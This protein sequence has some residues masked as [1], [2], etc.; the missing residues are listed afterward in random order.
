MAVTNTTLYFRT[1]AYIA[2]FLL[3]GVSLLNGTVQALLLAVWSGRFG[4]EGIPLRTNYTGI[5]ILDYPIAL[6]VAFFF[7]GTNGHDEGYQRFLLDAYSTL[8]SAFV[9]LYVETLR[10]GH[11]SKWINRYVILVFREARLVSSEGRPLVFGILWQCV[12]AAISLPVY[13]ALHLEWVS[14]TKIVRATKLDKARSIPVAFILGAVIP[15]LVGMAP[16]WLGPNVDAEVHQTILFFWQPD[17]VWVSGI[18]TAA[19]STSTWLFS[20]SAGG[21]N[22]Q[23][24]IRWW[25]RTSYLLAATSSALGHLYVAGRII[26]SNS[27]AVAFLRMYVPLQLVGPSGTEY[28]IFAG[29]PW[30]FLQFDFI[31]ISLSSLSWAFLLLR[32]TSLRRKLSTSGLTLCLTAGFLILGPGSTVSLA[33]LAREE[34]LP[35]PIPA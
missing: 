28:N 29:G 31:I 27:E 26:N 4:A 15:W 13:Y 5:P 12:G 19:V 1:L 32:E 23:A 8:Q 20:R 11:Q 24:K 6:L 17:P 25:V 10:P 7:Y 2:I 35:E 30:L 21:R 22:D 3:W 14:H 16:T 18:L 33:L 9:W 34:L